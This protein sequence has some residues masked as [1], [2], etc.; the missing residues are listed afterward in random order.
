MFDVRLIHELPASL[1]HPIIIMNIE[2][3]I[4]DAILQNNLV[5]FAGSGLSNNF[6]LPSWNNLVVEVIN[7]INKKAFNTLLPVLEMG[8]MQPIEVL[9]KIKSEHTIVKSYI[10]DNFNIKSSNNF[11]LHEK[12]IDLTGQVI[13]TN[14]D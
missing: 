8:I 4:K 1:N 3:K 12:I 11:D 5:I 13:T 14:Y 10:K 2:Q 7:K 6:N 9:E